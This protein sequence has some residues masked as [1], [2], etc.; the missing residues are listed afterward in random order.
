MRA[1]LIL[2]TLA[3]AAW[4]VRAATFYFVRHAER[5]GEMS[6]DPPLT[7]TG[8]ARARE[9]A[10]TLK[11]AR[12]TA[13]FV[14]EYQRTK[15]TAAPLAA[16][17]GIDPVVLAGRDLEAAAARLRTIAAGEETILVVGHTN[18][19][20]QLVEKLGGGAIAPFEET[21]YDRLVVLVTS[22]KGGA[23]LLTLR[24]GASQ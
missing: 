22:P 18:T 23:A 16:K 11:D 1:S 7:E 14:T 8:A 13:I 6:A 17:L 10:R 9:L 4:P 2:L 5:A 19:I 21:E 12:V 15:K 3:L 20:P 24:Y